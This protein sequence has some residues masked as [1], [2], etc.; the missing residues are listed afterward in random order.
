MIDLPLISMN[1]NSIT[2]NTSIFNK[3]NRNLFGSIVIWNKILLIAVIFAVFILPVLPVEWHQKLFHFVFT[4]IYFSA[5]LSIRRQSNS[6][7]FLFFATLMLEWVSA[8]FN[9]SVILAITK[10]V[11]VIFFLVIVGAL[12]KQIATSREVTSG[13]ILGSITGYLLLGIVYSIFISYIIQHDPE[14]FSTLPAEKIESG[15][16]I[17]MGI[18][19]YYSYVTL[20]T[21]GYGDIV[22]LKSYTRS[23]ATWIAISGQF[24][25]AI[26]VAL[27]VGKFSANRP[28]EK[29]TSDK[30]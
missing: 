7:L 4:I 6:I 2:S 30:D 3:L 1:D 9:F 13:V 29:E 26:I 5:I 24:Y 11:N 8:L 15:A 25:I 28:R 17:E 14:A 10:L 21:V 23:L 16:A 20:A 12:I 27:L 19:L 22:P 18:P